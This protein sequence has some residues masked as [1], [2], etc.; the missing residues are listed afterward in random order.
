M[1]I[2]EETLIV[3]HRDMDGLASALIA[4]Q[5]YKNAELKSIQYGEEEEFV[6]KYRGTQYERVLILDFSF[7]EKILKTLIHFI[8]NDLIWIDHHKS[9]MKYSMW[10]NKKIKGIRSVEKAACELTWK[11]FNTDV[12]PFS[13]CLIAD[14]DMWKFK[15]GDNTKAFFEYLHLFD[16]EQDISKIHNILFDEKDIS[17][18]IQKGELLVKYKMTMVKSICKHG[19]I[20]IFEGHKCFT[21][22]SNCHTSNIGNYAVNE[23]NC[24]ISRIIQT[25]WDESKNL[26]IKITSLRSKGNIDVSKIAEKYGGGGHHNASGYVQNI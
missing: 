18:Y 15:Y 8:C 2:M 5:K 7:S 20:E 24:E 23:Y 9:A 11:Y 22:Y 21:V 16:L 26:W 10:D 3:Y 19:R 25:K 12:I 13:I 14:W 4:L 17:V 1:N 6:E